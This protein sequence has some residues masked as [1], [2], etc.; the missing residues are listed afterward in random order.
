MPEKGDH[1]RVF[2]RLLKLLR[3]EWPTI[4]AGVLLLI[5]SMPC[6]LF[7][8]LV[9]KYVTDDIILAG[10]SEPTAVLSHLVPLGGRLHGWPALLTSA[11]CWLLVVYLIGE[12][13]GTFSNWIMQRVAQRFILSIRNRVY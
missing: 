12:A 10:K 4:S 8:G 5:L 6:E 2:P 11:L 3:P 9:W 13:L 7:P 1:D